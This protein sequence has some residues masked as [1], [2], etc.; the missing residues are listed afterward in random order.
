M[1]TCRRKF[2]RWPGKTTGFG[3]KTIIILP[4]TLKNFMEMAPV[5]QCVLVT[6]IR[7][8]GRLQEDTVEWVWIGSHEE[9]NK[10]LAS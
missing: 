6:I 2:R 4:C 9:Y 8:I 5:F 3:S 7:T 1:A 10:V